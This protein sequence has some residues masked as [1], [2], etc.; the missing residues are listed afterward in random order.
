M[1]APN[2]TVVAEGLA[3]AAEQGRPVRPVGGA[4]KLA[5]G[6]SGGLGY[7]AFTAARP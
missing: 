4:T 1:T 3:R 5:W 7:L 2:P 6:A